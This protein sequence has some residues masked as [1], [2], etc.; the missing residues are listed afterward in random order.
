MLNRVFGTIE[1]MPY[2]NQDQK[3]LVKGLVDLSVHR[4]RNMNKASVSQDALRTDYFSGLEDGFEYSKM[5]EI[6]NKKMVEYCAAQ[7]GIDAESIA[8]P[9][10]RTSTIFKEKVF[11]IVSLALP[12]VISAVTQYAFGQFADVRNVGWGDTAHFTLK[13]RE[14]FTVNT[15][16]KSGRRG[17]IQRTYETDLTIIPTVRE[18][19]VALDWYLFVTGRMDMGDWM[20]RI[21]LGFSTDI[22]YRVYKQ[23]DDAYGSLNAAFKAGSFTDA[24]WVSMA[25]KIS[26]ANGGLPVTAFG[27]LS[28]LGYVIPSNDYLKMQLGTTLAETGYLGRYKGVNLVQIPAVLKPGTVDNAGAFTF[29]TDNTRIYFFSLDTDKPVKIVFEGTPLSINESAESRADK[30]MLMSISQCYEAKIVTASVF[31]IMDVA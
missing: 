30:Q 15:S 25:E 24:N 22:N 16:N 10:T 3:D 11:Q 17:G 1:N 18:M 31:G 21:A 29:L 9:L 23:L 26:A 28:A 20:V 2:T 12:T 27:M 4:L 19:T 13:S 5:S 7:S 8:S 14:V 6:F